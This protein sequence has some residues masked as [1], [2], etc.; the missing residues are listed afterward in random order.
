[1]AD[2]SRTASRA[3]NRR[4]WLAGQSLVELAVSLPAMMIVLLGI[5]D[6]GRVFHAHVALT[7]AAH[8]GAVYGASSP[9]AASDSAGI[10][11]AALADTTTLWGSPPT[12]TSS[13]SMDPYGFQQVSVTVTYTFNPI[14]SF[15]GMPSSL[16]LRRSLT[17][18]VKP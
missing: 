3:G 12:V 6:T 11:A 1:M 15:P 14:I 18:R 10:S 9:T 5:A 4:R 13:T 2:S 7:G 17:M 8:N 16:L